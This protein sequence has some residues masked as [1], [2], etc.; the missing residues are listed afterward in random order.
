MIRRDPSKPHDWESFKKWFNRKYFPTKAR[1]KLEMKFLEL[2]Q[3]A[4]LVRD[5]EFE[6]NY[7]KRY[8][9]RDMDDEQSLICKFLHGMK[10]ELTPYVVVRDY[11][12]LSKLV[13]KAASIE[14]ALENQVKLHRLCK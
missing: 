4:R 14:T 7:L 9:G 1:F 3:E 10:T 11:N 8:T 13:K 2:R 5:Y 12:N 6:F